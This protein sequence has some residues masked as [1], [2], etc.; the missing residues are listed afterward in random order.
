MKTKYQQLYQNECGI[1]ALQNL[2]FLY[3]IPFQNIE[4]K[5]K[6]G[7]N[8]FEMKAILQSYFSKV[9]LIRCE[10]EQFYQKMFSPFILM[11]SCQTQLHFVVVISC[12]RKYFFI[13]DSLYEKC[14]RLT[15][16]QIKKMSNNIMI[17]VEP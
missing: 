8:L 9:Y 11:F 4:L 7:M 6:K 16:K 14:Y 17:L 13:M 2:L 10:I 3:H 5:E 15:L 12:K 1:K